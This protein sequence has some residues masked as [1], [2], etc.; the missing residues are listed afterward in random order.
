MASMAKRAKFLR[1]LL[2]LLK[3][4]FSK[5]SVQDQFVPLTSSKVVGIFLPKQLYEDKIL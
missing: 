2:L 4:E 3:Y 1:I 5:H